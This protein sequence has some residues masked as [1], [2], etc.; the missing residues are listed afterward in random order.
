MVHLPVLPARVA[1][2]ARRARTALPLARS[3]TGS[4]ARPTA[5][6]PGTTRA[7]VFHDGNSL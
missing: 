3:S 4:I 5:S 6:D 2:S 1:R 7:A